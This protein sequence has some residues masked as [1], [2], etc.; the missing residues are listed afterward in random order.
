MSLE[1][2]ARGQSLLPQCDPDQTVKTSL[3]P[4]TFASSLA[5]S[6]PGPWPD[7]A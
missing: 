1:S 7:K 3:K 2:C 5:K 6:D 4:F